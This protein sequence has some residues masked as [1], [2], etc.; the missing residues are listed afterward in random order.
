MGLKPNPAC[1]SPKT[2]AP[3]PPGPPA[4][5]GA[6]TGLSAGG[7]TIPSL[8]DPSPGSLTRET[9]AFARLLR[10]HVGGP[11]GRALLS[12]GK[13]VP[14]SRS[15]SQ[16]RV[17][18]DDGELRESKGGVGQSPHWEVAPASDGC[19]FESQR[20]PWFTCRGS[21]GELLHPIHFPHLKNGPLQGLKV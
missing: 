6:G 11:R 18:H 19:E 21:S 4:E 20:L 1:I 12:I 13:A 17:R 3:G 8:S 5:Q 10:T 16:S 9:E 2:P 7:I 15:R 14:R